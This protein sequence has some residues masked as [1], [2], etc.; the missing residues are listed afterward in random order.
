MEQRGY[1][2][3]TIG[4]RFA[5]VAGFYRYAVIDGVL[6]V[7]PTLAVTR[8]SV[9]WEG[10][11]RTVLHP[12][13]F[14]AILTAARR[15]GP[16]SHALVAL[17][18]M[19]GLRVGEACRINV[20]DLHQQAGYELLHVVGKGNKPA[21]I[22]LPIPVL[23]AVREAAGD[24]LSGPLL[25]NRSGERFR[26]ASVAARITK[27]AKTAGLTTTVSPHGLRRTFCTAGLIAGVPLRDMQYA[28]RHADARTTTRYDMAR[29]NL[30]RHASHAVAAYL[31][32]MA[33]G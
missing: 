26:R 32:G 29:A 6:A 33:S 1:A 8:P 11:R 14:A 4:R 3:A 2:P 25:L 17:L 28:M 7:D 10:Q 9:P 15:D 22:P 30:D 31:A 27:L 23:R 5:T 19:I 13:E 16:H 12:L 18:G 21:T 24:R 20:S